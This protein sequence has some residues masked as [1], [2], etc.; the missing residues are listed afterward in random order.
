[1]QPPLSPLADNAHTHQVKILQR[2]WIGALLLQLG[3]IG[4]SM[5]AVPKYDTGRISLSVGVVLAMA[6]LIALAFYLV[7]RWERARLARLPLEISDAM[8]TL[9]GPE[10][11][12]VFADP[13]DA[14]TRAVVAETG[15]VLVRL[16]LVTLIAYGAVLTRYRGASLAFA[17]ALLAI[18]LFLEWRLFPTLDRITDKLERVKGVRLVP[19]H[20]PIVEPPI[21]FAAPT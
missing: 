9:G 13:R 2:F 7:D 19:A 18:T 5:S 3:A 15:P 4:M 17:L 11:R 20:G 16:A 14:L 10:N 8:S 1:M 21:H 6:M 12:Y